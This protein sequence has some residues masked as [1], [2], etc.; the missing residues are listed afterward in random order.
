MNNIQNISE[1][2]EEKIVKNSN[3]K[4]DSLNLNRIRSFEQEILL[5]NEKNENSKI[6][7]DF[8]DKVMTHAYERYKEKIKSKKNYSQ[9]DLFLLSFSCL[10]NID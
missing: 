9:K 5:I 4:H 7:N 3:L 2:S 6:I 8:L 10:C 1:K